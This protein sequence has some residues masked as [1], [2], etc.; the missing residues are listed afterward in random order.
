MSTRTWSSQFDLFEAFTRGEER[1]FD[2]VHRQLFRA[3]VYFSS[4]ITREADWSA[5]I[6]SE[7]F[8]KAWERRKEFRT[9]SGLKSFLYVSTRNASIDLIRKSKQFN[10][11]RLHEIN[12]VGL[13]E[14]SI[15]H[16]I[17]KAETY[18][19]LH[20]AVESLPSQAREVIRLF[21]LLGEDYKEIARRLNLSVNTV[22]VQ[23]KRA[24]NM[25]KKSIWLLLP[26][27]I[28]VIHHFFFSSFK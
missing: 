26:G 25:L 24:L 11:E 2:F 5:D 18:R 4:Q 19:Q 21:Y 20:L 15:E 16:L 1:G 27:L 17:I 9:F 3:L 12:Q 10:T 13:S 6:V 22:R 8:V 14:G 28:S 23:K 7:Q